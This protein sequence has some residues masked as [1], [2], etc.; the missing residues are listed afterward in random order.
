MRQQYDEEYLRDL[1]K[2]YIRTEDGIQLPPR[3]FVYKFFEPTSS[4]GSCVMLMDTQREADI[5]LASRYKFEPLKDGECFI[6]K[7]MANGL[8][9][10]VGDVIY[11]KFDVK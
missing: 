11:H 2:G 7:K 3:T 5:G 1:E 6:D 8:Q 4:T 9:V 10:E